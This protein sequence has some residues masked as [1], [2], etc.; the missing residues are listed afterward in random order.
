V[1]VARD[2][3]TRGGRIA[4]GTLTYLY[5]ALI[6]LLPLGWLAVEG[7]DFGWGMLVARLGHP[8]CLRA[9]GLTALIALLSAVLNG[10]FGIALA[11]VFARQ[12]FR[13]RA[14]ANAFID[15]PFAI[16]PVVAGLM[17]LLVY[18]PRGLLGFFFDGVGLPVVFALPGMV[19][20]T[21][22]VTFP[23]VVRELIP[24]LEQAGTELE[25]AARTLG[26][27]PWTVFRKVTLPTIRWALAYG[28]M[29]TV[30]RALGEFG[31]V[32]VVSGNIVGRTQTAP[33]YVYQAFADFDMPTT[34]AASLVLILLALV[35]LAALGVWKRRRV[36]LE[37]KRT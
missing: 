8:H 17:I 5:F 12:R 1:T 25:E 26:A 16:S 14:L 18:G 33:L 22:F 31:A 6:V 30:A 28:L 9:F 21:V 24:V 35:M 27:S 7:L 32:L 20:A 19:L 34:Y 3:T 29:L 23:F 4:V 10:V 15:V 13:G 2:V 11:I 37:H 36:R